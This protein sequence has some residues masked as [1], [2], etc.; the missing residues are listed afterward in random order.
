MGKDKT[1]LYAGDILRLN[2]FNHIS[3]INEQAGNT[4]YLKNTVSHE[5]HIKQKYVKEIGVYVNEMK[6]KSKDMIRNID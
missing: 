1:D 6:K 4:A 3:S 2:I 5:S